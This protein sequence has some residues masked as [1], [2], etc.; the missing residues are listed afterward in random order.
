MAPAD[1]GPLSMREDVAFI[2]RLVLGNCH[3]GMFVI[4]KGLNLDDC[5]FRR[6][7]WS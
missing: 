1:F 2:Q 7:W 5:H 3:F 4:L 6:V